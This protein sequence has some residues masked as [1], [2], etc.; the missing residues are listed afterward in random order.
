MDT[1]LPPEKVVGAV[2]KK[3]FRDKQHIPNV[4]KRVSSE[5]ISEL[6]DSLF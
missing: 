1:I 5:C 2:E 3:A 6:V 4:G